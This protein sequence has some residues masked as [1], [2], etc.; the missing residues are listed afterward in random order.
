MT[1][2]NEARRGTALW[3]TIA[4]MASA[5]AVGRLVHGGDASPAVFVCAVSL[6]PGA[7]YL[8]LWRHRRGRRVRR[9]P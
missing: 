2:E 5:I 9:C 3:F 1:R 7:L 8:V 6:V 4:A